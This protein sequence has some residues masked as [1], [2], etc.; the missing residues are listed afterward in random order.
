VDRELLK[1]I[2]IPAAIGEPAN[3]TKRRYA[4]DRRTAPDSQS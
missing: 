4:T 2:F 1:K 3:L